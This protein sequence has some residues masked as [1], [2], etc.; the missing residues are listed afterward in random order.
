[1]ARS[2]RR[3]TEPGSSRPT[4][5][6]RI[7]RERQRLGL[8]QAELAGEEM[9]KSFISQVEADLT[10]PS[11][12]NLQLL[13]RRLNRPVSYFLDEPDVDPPAPPLQ[14]VHV[15][16][17][18]RALAREGATALALETLDQALVEPAGLDPVSRA[19]ILSLRADLVASSGPADQAAQAFQQ[20]VDAWRAVEDEREEASILLAWARYEL[21]RNG[22][23]DRVVRLLERALDRLGDRPRDP[24]LQASLQAELGLVYARRGSEAEAIEHLQAALLAMDDLTDFARY[25]EVALTLGRLLGRAG[26]HQAAR[27]MV[28]RSLYFFQALGDRERIIDGHLHFVWVLARSGDL[29][30]ARRAAAEATRI[31][32]ELPPAHRLQGSVLRARAWLEALAGRFEGALALWTEALEQSQGTDQAHVH[33]ELARLFWRAGRLHE[34]QGHLEAA[35]ALLEGSDEAEAA[36]LGPLREELARIAGQLGQPHRAASLFAAALEWFQKKGGQA[37]WVNSSDLWLLDPPAV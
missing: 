15:L 7:R 4:L 20:A 33:R 12:R 2:G 8:T 29:E 3:G 1:M 27:V 22:P 16:Q 5:G 19:R 31:V 17:Q 25:G 14:G 24:W 21:S 9:T 26:E 34:A 36:P 11:L 37:A 13:A 18:A 28:E 30:G 32:R 6:E 10:R 35:L 23:G